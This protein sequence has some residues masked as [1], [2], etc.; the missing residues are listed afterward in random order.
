MKRGQSLIEATLVLIVFFT[1]LLG[2]I[3]AARCYFPSGAG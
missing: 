1:M 3:D 2:V